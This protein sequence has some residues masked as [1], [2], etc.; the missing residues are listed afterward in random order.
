MLEL[1]EGIETDYF[2]VE[3]LSKFIPNVFSFQ[4]TRSNIFKKCQDLK[5]KIKD[6]KKNKKAM[7]NK[8]AGA[9]EL[10][11]KASFKLIV[12]EEESVEYEEFSFETE[13]IMGYIA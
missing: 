4:C 1:C 6:F 9:N 5:T 7:K 2:L 13:N 8:K 11:S 12:L 10:L 3:N